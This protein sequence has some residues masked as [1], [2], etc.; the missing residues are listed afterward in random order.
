[1]ID[2]SKLEFAEVKDVMESTKIKYRYN[3]ID[4]KN[5][6]IFRYD[7]AKHHNELSTFP[8]HKHLPDKTIE[9]SE[10]DLH[11]VLDEVK[12]IILR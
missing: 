12:K 10:P 3:F 8:H 9:S 6:L 11:E 4:S 2:K 1:L 5:E 7:N